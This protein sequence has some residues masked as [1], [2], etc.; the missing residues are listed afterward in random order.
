VAERSEAAGATL[1]DLQFDIEPGFHLL[2]VQRGGRYIYRPRGHVVLEPGDELIASGPDEGH[3]L[4][5][6]RCGWHLTEDD[7]TGEHTLAPL[8]R[9][10]A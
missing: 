9:A 3:A 5:A 7:D 1:A 8:D 2:A 4:L 6:A 10:R